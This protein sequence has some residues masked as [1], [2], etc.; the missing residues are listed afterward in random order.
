[1]VKMHVVSDLHGDAV[2]DDLPGGDSRYL[3]G[4]SAVGGVE[5]AFDR[6]DAAA[7]AIEEDKADGALCSPGGGSGG[8]QN[9]V[10]IGDLEGIEG[11]GFVRA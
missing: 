6:V 4:S 1:M 7:L 11:R 9:H 3:R 2:V 5:D 8:E 10:G